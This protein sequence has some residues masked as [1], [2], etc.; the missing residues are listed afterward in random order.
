MPAGLRG[1]DSGGDGGAIDPS[2][3]PT[4][5]APQGK[6]FPN[7]VGLYV[8]TEGLS[9]GAGAVELKAKSEIVIKLGTQLDA[10]GTA[11]DITRNTDLVISGT[12]TASGQWVSSGT[13]VY[14]PVST[15]QEISFHDVNAS[16][17]SKFKV[18]VNAPSEY[19]VYF[20]NKA[21]GYYEESS[22]C[23]YDPNEWTVNADGNSTSQILFFVK[24]RKEQGMPAGKPLDI[25]P[26][27][28]TLRIGL[29]Y[30]RNGQ[31]AGYLDFSPVEKVGARDVMG[32]ILTSDLGSLTPDDFKLN[33]QGRLSAPFYCFSTS[34]DV[35]LVLEDF[36]AANGQTNHRLKQIITPSVVVNI[37]RENDGTDYIVEFYSASQSMVNNGV[38]T[39]SPGAAAFATYEFSTTG[40]EDNPWQSTNVTRK[41][42]AFPNQSQQ[43]S[44]SQDTFSISLDY[45]DATLVGEYNAEWEEYKDETIAYLNMEAAW[46]A[47]TEE[48]AAY[49]EANDA[50]QEQLDELWEAYYDALDEWQDYVNSRKSEDASY[51]PASDL[52]HPKPTPPGYNDP[53][54]SNE[55]PPEPDPVPCPPGDGPHQP[56]M[57][58]EDTLAYIDV[59]LPRRSITIIGFNGARTEFSASDYD[60]ERMPE[61]HFN[62]DSYQIARTD[63]SMRLVGRY[64]AGKVNDGDT[65]QGGGAGGGGGT[66]FVMPNGNYGGTG[67]GGAANGGGVAGIVAVS[68]EDVV[69]LTGGSDVWSNYNG[70]DYYSGESGKAFDFD[71]PNGDPANNRGAPAYVSTREVAYQF[72]NYIVGAG[73][74]NGFRPDLPN[75][76]Y[77]YRTDREY[78]N[79]DLGTGPMYPGRLFWEENPDRSWA[80]YSYHTDL[81]KRGLT[82][83]VITPFGDTGL[84]NSLPANVN[85]SGYCVKTTDY[86]PDWNG[87]VRL[88]SFEENWINGTRVSWSNRVYATAGTANG[89][90]VWQAT[91]TTYAASDPSV[92]LTGITKIYQGKGIDPLYRGLPYS[93]QAVDGTKT[94]YAYERGTVDAQGGFTASGAGKAFRTI[95]VTGIA[96]AGTGKLPAGCSQTIDG[97][98]YVDGRS[99]RVD[100]I[101]DTCGLV[102]YVKTYA[103]NNSAWVLLDTEKRTYD[104]CS[105]LLY[106]QNSTGRA[107]YQYAIGGRL[108]SSTDASGVI[109]DY[110][111][112]QFG[113][114]T[115]ASQHA[116]AGVSASQTQFTYDADG[117]VT[118]KT[119]GSNPTDRLV[120]TYAYNYAGQLTSKTEQEITTTY[121]YATSSDGTQ[122][123][124]ATETH[125]DGSS[126]TTTKNRDGTIKSK[127]G[128]AIVPEYYTY[129]VEGKNLAVTTSYGSPG[130]PRWSKTWKDGL[131]RVV[132][133]QAPLATGTSTSISTV[134]NIY[135]AKG[136]LK[137]TKTSGYADTLYNYDAFGVLTDTALVSSAN[138]TISSTT[139]RRNGAT[140]KIVNRESAWWRYDDTIAY[141]VA[142][143]SGVTSSKT[144]TRLTGFTSGGAP[145]CAKLPIAGTKVSEVITQ[146]SAGNETRSMVFVDRATG[147]RYDV[148]TSAIGSSP[149]VTLSRAGLVLQTVSAS[150]VISSISYDALARPVR[151][152]DRTSA[153]S[154]YKGSHIFYVPNT[155]R[156][157]RTYNDCG[158][159]VAKFTYDGVGRVFSTSS[160]AIAYSA[161]GSPATASENNLNTTTYQYNAR[162]QTISV[163]GTATNPVTYVFNDYGDMISQAT[164]RD[165]SCNTPDTTSFERSPIDGSLISRTDAKGN[166]ASFTYNIRG[167]IATVQSARAL[168]GSTTPIKTAYNYDG[169]TG[170]LTSVTYT[171]GTPSISYAY[172]RMG[173]VT[174]VKDATG[175]R[176]FTYRPSDLRIDHEYLGQTTPGSADATSVYGAAN[177]TLNYVY[178]P[179]NGAPSVNSGFTLT[180]NAAAGRQDYTFSIAR[181]AQTGRLASIT[182][183]SDRSGAYRRGIAGSQ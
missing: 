128:T 74:L 135:N 154:N 91:S 40:S 77:G 21:L 27:E 168:A 87:A 39:I 136:R 26:G 122:I 156:K 109:T 54:F 35:K 38:Y 95:M 69:T 148:S 147:S 42:G 123:L 179:M 48:Y 47:Y 82:A 88:P 157:D 108:Q 171:D 130:S 30:L 9:S 85:A 79:I 20:Y 172:D 127:T 181:D 55:G 107:D 158:T 159:L 41:E 142:G 80:M 155:S 120:S 50:Y 162:G 53:N 57:A 23:E 117:R 60:N 86:A 161:A 76:N 59:P 144:W 143:S 121:S 32:S 140:L 63:S 164:Y 29:G 167:Q 94:C 146:D 25:T 14:L 124:S 103:R 131:G 51:D 170:D 160:P 141:P 93:V 71:N 112:D 44:F 100:T 4:A 33:L 16:N 149:S 3:I 176:N 58:R 153:T 133:T 75:G 45:P 105:N 6:E 2:S 12:A 104:A 56:A 138:A 165:E 139:G 145:V 118:S 65:G 46:D 173:R 1:D 7:S 111:Y 15:Q 110:T 36:L 150:G 19:A 72:K 31:S 102:I 83:R 180:A 97:I 66:Y 84:P 64:G 152:E 90:P 99:T 78:Y 8:W 114:V 11:A 151:I 52:A 132:Q 5:G 10:S 183:V 37:D 28:T 163:K 18:H 178:G 92:G 70:Y 68:G 43:A 174:S 182:T 137:R 116:L 24:L 22:A 125:A 169:N 115:S 166:I 134:E 34:P 73:D 49:E 89:Q 175:A 177:L 101:R 113:H 129:S 96:A 67:Q 98:S 13:A 61:A 81:N 62:G 17:M 119:T 106:T 126:I